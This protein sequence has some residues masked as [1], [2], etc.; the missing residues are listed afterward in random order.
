MEV[1]EN[2]G[3]W[4]TQ[5]LYGHNIL[6]RPDERVGDVGKLTG[7]TAGRGASEDG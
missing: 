1:S 5:L 3:P 6:H 2:D 4:D 7:V